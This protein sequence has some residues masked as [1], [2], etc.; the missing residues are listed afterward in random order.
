MPENIVSPTPELPTPEP[1]STDPVVTMPPARKKSPILLFI[2]LVLLSVVSVLAIY[3]FLQ[4]RTLTLEQT[5]PSPTPTPAASI[6]PTADW[7]TYNGEEFE[8]KYPKQWTEIEHSSNFTDNLTFQ[9]PDQSN[10]NVYIDTDKKYKSLSDYL[11]AMDK[12]SRT[13]YEGA[14][15]IKIL[16]SKNIESNNFQAVQRSEEWLAA[17]FTTTVTYVW[18]EGLVGKL[19]PTSP[20]STQSSLAHS[21]YDQILS[22]FKFTEATSS[23]EYTCPANGWQ[24]CMP[25]LSEEGKRACSQEAMNWYRANCPDFQ[26]AAL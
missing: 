24:S 1:I 4:V 15:A 7:N 2:A 19:Y 8:F 25:V 5:A 14:P 17:G 12:K 3:L 13:S 11:A 20:D 9:A 10:L 26:G 21:N 23:S 18:H 6:D 22:T 16:A